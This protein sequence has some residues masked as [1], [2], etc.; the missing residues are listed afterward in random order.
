MGIGLTI[1]KTIITA[2]G[3][4]IHAKNNERGAEFYFSLPKEE[5]SDEF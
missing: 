1:C 5:L 3:G 4:T 2:H